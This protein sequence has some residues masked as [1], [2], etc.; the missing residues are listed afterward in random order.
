MRLAF[1]RPWLFC[2]FWAVKGIALNGSCWTTVGISIE[3][4]LCVWHNV[5]C[6]RVHLF[7]TTPIFISSVLI[8][9]PVFFT[10]TVSQND[11]DQGFDLNV[12]PTQFAL[13]EGLKGYQFYTYIRFILLFVLPILALIIFNSLIFKKIYTL[14]STSSIDQR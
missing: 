1:S 13:E 2:Y 5:N 3:R 7:Y 10:F 4:Y 11:P 6:K 14:S 12:Q 9:L 8:N